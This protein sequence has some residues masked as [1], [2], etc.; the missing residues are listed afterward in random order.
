MTSNRKTKAVL[1]KAAKAA[2]KAKKAKKGET[3]DGKEEL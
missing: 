1:R 3:V 2:K